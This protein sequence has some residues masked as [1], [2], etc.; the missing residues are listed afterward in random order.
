[1]ETINQMWEGV[2][3]YL[4]GLEDLSEPGY[5]VWIKAIEPRAIEENSF[6]VYVPSN[7]QRNII[8]TNYAPLIKEAFMQVFALP[9][10][11]TIIT[12]EDLKSE[13]SPITD[14]NE[15]FHFEYTFDNFVVGSSNNFAHA[16]AM[17]VA[18]NPGGA[19]NPLF[20]YGDSGLGKTHLLL[21]IKNYISKANPQ[22]RILYIKG[23][24]LTN[25]LIESVQKGPN[26][27]I[28]FRAKYR[29]IDVLLVD[30][31][32]FLANK[33]STQE[34]FFHTFEALH[35]AH[36]QIVLA[37]DRPPKEISPL[38]DR[39]RNRFEMGLMADVKAPDLETRVAIIRSKAELLNVP[40]SAEVATV[41]AE[42]LKDNVRQ[43]EGAVKHLL[44]QYM[45]TGERPTL[46]TAQNVV[47]DVRNDS[48]PLP[49]TIDS[50]ISEVSRVTQVSAED[51]RST[52]RTG[53]VSLAR[54]IAIYVVR[55]VTNMST[56]A[57][58]S[59][60][61]NRDHST[62]IYTI[63]K[64]EALMKKDPTF[65]ARVNDIIKNVCN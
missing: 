40:V 36:K 50:V 24:T 13:A 61:G 7:L 14:A 1:M 34:E 10:E 45:L 19:F 49:V 42:Q 51:I 18:K 43:L 8:K 47:R 44:A 23:E 32:Q 38:D 62:V 30:D 52:K 4:R 12:D 53:A 60:F 41:I 5:N 28:A 65:R 57:I 21:A 26:A 9:L 17:S 27:M 55:T 16:A 63:N 64:I 6:V 31:I 22:L 2:L 54:Q 35:Q 3:A 29:Q 15:N 25:E 56:E 46:L 58:G 48:Q 33:T 37:S 20:I 11:L 39:L 59:E